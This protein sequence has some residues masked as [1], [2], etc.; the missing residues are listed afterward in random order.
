[1][2][3]R[4]GGRSERDPALLAGFGSTERRRSRTY[5][6]VGYTTSPVLKTGWATGPMPLRPSGY[7]R[8]GVADSDVTKEV[9]R[10]G[11]VVRLSS[12]DRVL[13]PQDGITKADL[14]DYYAA[15]GP[16][17]V[18]HLRNRPFTMKRYRE[19][20]D[21]PG[22]FQKDAPKGMPDWLPRRPFRTFPREGGSRIAN[23]ALVND[24]LALLWMVQM[25]CIDM[26]AWYS[27]VDKPDR[28]DF[29]L[30]DLDPPDDGFALTVRV[31]HLIREALESLELESYVKTSGADGIHVLVPI[32]RRH[33][34]DETYDFAEAA[35]RL[36]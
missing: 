28:P 15:I 11:R 25:H 23:F 20:I 3:H 21:G 12:P 6:A 31:A 2:A 32:A 4:A 10:G 29:V 17:I 13:F 16:A 35:S 34:F 18:P 22:F 1:Q 8:R 5:P 14:F 27:R 9:R 7:R 33:G 36:L 19:G 26:N 30:F 24:E